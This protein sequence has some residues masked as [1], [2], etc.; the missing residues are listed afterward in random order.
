MTLTA[1]RAC[2]L[3]VY[4]PETGTLSRRVARAG[5]GRALKAKSKDGYLALSVD[6][7]NYLGHRVIFLIVA[8]R[9]PGQIDHINRDR[10]DNRWSNLRE[11]TSQENAL[12]RSQRVRAATPGVSPTLG[13]KFCARASINARRVRCGTFDTAEAAEDAIRRARGDVTVTRRRALASQD[14]EWR[15]QVISASSTDAAAAEVLGI[16]RR[17]VGKWRRKNMR[18]PL[19]SGTTPTRP[20]EP[21]LSGVQPSPAA[22]SPVRSAGQA[23]LFPA[24]P[25]SAEGSSHG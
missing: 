17:A 10:M 21:R 20:D 24:L 3:F 16:T 1:E 18:D 6:G 25:L 7:K 8:G 14:A 22:A 5:A 9:W 12:N 4:A 2:E 19:S 11:V 13:G 23:D 15:K